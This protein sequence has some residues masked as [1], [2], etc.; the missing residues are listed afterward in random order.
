[1]LSTSG[2]GGLPS[3]T[4]FLEEPQRKPP[5]GSID[6][7]LGISALGSVGDVEG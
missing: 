1:M 3:V 5:T 6:V 4:R 2:A 7:L